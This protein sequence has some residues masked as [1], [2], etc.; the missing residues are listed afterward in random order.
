MVD[1][2]SF[3]TENVRMKKITCWSTVFVLLGMFFFS[4]SLMA[5]D[6]EEDVPLEEVAIGIYTNQIYDMSLRD[7][8]FC[9]DFYVWFRWKNNNLKPYESFEVVNGRT[10]SKE[11]IYNEPIDEN[12]QYAVARV[13][14]TV[15]KFWDIEKFPLDNHVL[16]VE[17]EDSQNEAHKLVYVADEKNTN[18]NPQVQVPGWK[19]GK[20]AGYSKNHGYKTNYGDVSLPSDAES[21]YSRFVFSQEI[22]RPGYGYFIKLFLSVFISALIAM[23]A[24]LIKPTDLDPRFGLGIGSIFAAVASEYVVVSSLPETNL[25][26]LAD[27]L[28]ILAILFIFLSIFESVISLKLFSNGHEKASI[29]LDKLMLTLMLV[30]YI[31]GNIMIV[32]F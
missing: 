21:N 30:A 4:G 22:I 11:I 3:T 13:N 1:Y 23:L 28:H 16:T 14:A 27:R 29:R 7:N 17:I 9:I 20:T 18:I 5:E 12:T 15:T 32:F 10:D 31:V 2:C 26:T 19:L 24:L 8:K 6:Q 25:I